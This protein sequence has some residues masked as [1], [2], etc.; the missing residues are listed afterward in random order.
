[1]T[2]SNK[3]I[4]ENRNDASAS[5]GGVFNP[6][7]ANFAADLTTDTNTGNTASPIVSSASYN[8]VAGDVGHWVFIQS[9]TNWTPGWYLIAS[10]AA[11]K[12]TLTAGV[13]TAVLYGT[14]STGANYQRPNGL[15]TAAGCATVGTPTSGVWSVDYSQNASAF[16][17]FTDMVID[18]VTN[19]DFTSAA[20][21]VD[22][23][24]IGNII[25]VTSGTGFTVQRVE[26]ISIPSGVIGR[27]DK[28]LGTLGST[29][30]NGALGGAVGT[31]A[32]LSALSIA[33]IVAGN[34]IFIKATG[35]YTLTVTATV[36]AAA[37][38]D[39]TNGRIRVE[40][41]T[42]YRGEMDGRPTITSA[43]NSVALITC[44]DND[45]WEFKHLKVTHTAA[46]KA[47]AFN[48]VTVQSTPCW[49]MDC[50]SDGPLSMFGGSFQPA[51]YHLEAVEIKNATSAVSA[52]W[53]IN[54]GTSSLFMYGC[55]IHDN[56]CDGIRWGSAAIMSLQ[57]CIFDSNTIAINSPTT[58]L[59]TTLTM[60]GCVIV[61]NSSDGIKIAA[62]SLVSGVTLELHCNVFYGNGGAAI[63]NLDE[64][65][66]AD[67][68][69]RINRN[70]AYGSNTSPNVGL[71]ADE[72]DITLTADPFTN[73][74]GR[75]F[76]PN[77]T[78]G[79]GALLRPVGG[80]PSSFPGAYVSG[81]TTDYK[82]VGIQH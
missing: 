8:F 4:W 49:F 45:Y 20:N 37:K 82:D 2:F 67:A 62:T 42:T 63:N 33:G 51:S 9:G 66:M 50:I 72:S 12:A 35:T 7:N 32:L 61:D 44:N 26:I 73:K 16:L 81:T 30:G 68:N 6:A 11:N 78:A 40:G 22:V 58:T 27:V 60:H 34:W 15:N 19:T 57:D 55:D 29:G 64:Q 17:T 75:D 52:L 77:T 24:M 36:T 10:V 38:G 23:N 28:S 47:V 43:T 14:S 56:S 3:L 74:A 18:A 31:S 25:N 39:V 80:V 48:F 46:T 1:M 5:N 69:I 65:A 79:G 71:A 76:T 59:A 41:Y 13:G 70:N 21:P 54:S 53:N